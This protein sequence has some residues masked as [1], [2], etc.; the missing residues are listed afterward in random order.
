MATTTPPPA[1]LPSAA[2]ADMAASARR[3]IDK[4]YAEGAG[5]RTASSG[6]RSE[7]GGGNYAMPD[8]RRSR[9]GARFVLQRLRAYARD[10]PRRLEAA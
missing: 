9:Y 8:V 4:L 6:R 3:L 7:D 1:V 5:Q 10:R 2:S